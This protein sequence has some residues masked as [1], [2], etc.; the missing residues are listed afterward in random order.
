[1]PSGL[2]FGF[3]LRTPDGRT[4]SIVEDL[5]IDEYAP[6]RLDENIEELEREAVVAGI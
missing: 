1:V 6:S 4:W 3:P 5:Y 2:V